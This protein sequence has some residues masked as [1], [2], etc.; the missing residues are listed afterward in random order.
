M[1]TAFG[2]LSSIAGGALPKRGGGGGGGMLGPSNNLVAY[3]CDR[4]VPGPFLVLV[5]KRFHH[6]RALIES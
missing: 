2:L 6:K 1:V 5:A 3:T 4:A